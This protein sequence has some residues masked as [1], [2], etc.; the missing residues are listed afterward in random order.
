MVYYFLAQ[1]INVQFVEELKKLTENSLYYFCLKLVRNSKIFIID[2]EFLGVK[3]LGMEFGQIFN[4][5]W[6]ATHISI[7]Y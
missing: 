7:I 5:K 4:K 6:K 1:Y 2:F 3:N